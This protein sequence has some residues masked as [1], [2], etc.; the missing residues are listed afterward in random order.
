MDALAGGLAHVLGEG[1]TQECVPLIEPV[2]RGQPSPRRRYVLLALLST[3]LVAALIWLVVAQRGGGNASQ[4]EA[5]ADPN[6][7]PVGSVWKGGF[8]F[9]PLGTNDGDLVVQITARDGDRFNG[10]YTTEKGSYEWRI[11]GIVDG[12]NIRWKFTEAL[13][14]DNAEQLVGK[15]TVEGTLKGATIV[16]EFHDSADNS[17]AEIKITR[18]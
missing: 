4:K 1:P 9:L 16:G 3:G 17:H 11:A 13:K 15:G 8:R 5:E 12:V 14:G 2:P 6:S 7:L 18:E 10:V